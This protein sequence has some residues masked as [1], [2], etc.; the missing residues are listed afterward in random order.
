MKGEHEIEREELR[1]NENLMDW[2][3]K[4]AE[5]N[6]GALTVLLT[7]M[8]EK[9]TQKMGELILFLDDMNIRGTQIWIGYK[10]YCDCDID[11][12]VDCV[13]EKDQVMIDKIN[14]IGRKGNQSWKAV[15]HSAS[16]LGREFLD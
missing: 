13:K 12:F 7:A 9:G 8:K 3:Q 11:K 15:P 16:V 5:G 4:M 2:L 6:P 14:E 10:D 1:L